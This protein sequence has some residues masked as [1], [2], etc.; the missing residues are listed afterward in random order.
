MGKMIRR[1]IEFIESSFIEDIKEIVKPIEE[2]IS[3]KFY[4]KIFEWF[5]ANYPN[6]ALMIYG[7]KIVSKT[8]EC[9][10]VVGLLDRP[11][12]FEKKDTE[13]NISLSFT[14]CYPYQYVHTP[15]Q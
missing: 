2:E 4:N 15:K 9:E 6:S 12:F 8:T 1:K 10:K 5:K 3:I 14:P 11:V 13:C 7:D